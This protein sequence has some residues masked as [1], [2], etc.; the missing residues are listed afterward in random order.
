M[1]ENLPENAIDLLPSNQQK[2][3]ISKAIE[4]RRQGLSYQDIGKYF[5]CTKQAAHHALIPYTIVSKQLTDYKAHRAD[6][7]ADVGREIL[8]SIDQT[9][10]Q[11]AS[12]LQKTT[13]MA[14]LYDKERLERDLSTVNLSIHADI[15]AMKASEDAPGSTNAE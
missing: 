14:V 15:K 3:D 9:D 8:F 10:I 13:A 5:G 2:M 7:Y 6:L 12:L 1:T 11:K 4:L